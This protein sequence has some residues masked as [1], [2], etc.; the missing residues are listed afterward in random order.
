MPRAWIPPLLL[1]LLAVAAC[2]PATLTPAVTPLAPTAAPAE[3]TVAQIPPTA[4]SAPEEPIYLALIWHQHQPLYYKDPATGVYI[5]PWVRVHAAKDYLDMATTL[6]RYPQVKATFNLTPSLIRQL[7]D[8]AAGAKDLYQ[9]LAEKPAD[10]LTPEDKAFIGERFFDINPKIIARFPRYQE[11]A[12]LRPNQAAWGEAEW[13]DLQVLFNLAWT[14]PDWLAAEPLKGLVQK[15]RGFSE[16]DKE[17]LFARHLEIVRQVIPEHRK[18]QDAGQIEVTMTPYAHPI[19]PLLVS[20]RLARQSAPGLELPE[21]EFSYAQDA[22]AQLQKGVAFYEQHF[23]RPPRGMWPAE[24]AVAQ[25]IVGMVSQAGIRWM[26]SDEEVL[27]RSLGLA[28]FKRDAQETV[29]EA[30]TLYR[31]Y[32]VSS[33][34][35]PPVAII[36]RDKLISDKVGFAYAFE[37]G[38]QAARDFI[39]RIHAIRERLQAQGQAGAHLVSVILDGEN[40]WEYY[41]NDGKLFLNTLYRLLAEDPL[42]VTVTPAEF[43]AR[44]PAQPALENLWAGSWVSPDFKTWIGEEEENIAWDYLART[45]AVVSLYERGERTIAADRLAR[46]MELIYAA[47][48]SD[49]FWWYGADQNSGNDES[50]DEQF[51]AI[52]GDI[53]DT[54][55]LERPHWL[56][57]PIIASS[58]APTPVPTLGPSTPVLV[59]E[60]PAGDDTGPGTYTYPLDPVF[61]KAAYDLKTFEVLHNDTHVLFRFT[62]YGKLN[63][64]WGAPNGMGVHTVDVYIDQDGKEGSGLRKLLP[65]RNAAVSARDAWDFA[66]WAEGWYPAMYRAGPQGPEEVEGELQIISDAG[67]QQITLKVPKAVIGNDPQK[68]KYLAVVLSQEGY[69]AAG[70]WRVRDVLPQAQQWRLGGAPSDTNHTR[71]LDVALPADFTPDQAT[72]LRTYPPSQETDMDR[73]GP[74]DFAQLPMIKP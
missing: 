56:S 12:N 68:W 24:G 21:E 66:I 61:P 72:L 31:P 64:A 36:F 57:V 60:D 14:D 5:R 34:E 71:I 54:L 4:T 42:I 43:L 10:Q 33:N 18:L 17:V 30:S 23:G 7:D 13:R 59:V 67:R 9:V 19:L 46:A 69:P 51:R 28:K 73:L 63:N 62:F 6:A 50:F 49:W 27:A 37:P 11:L 70:V 44:F 29:V 20:T 74:D 3:P 16:A 26:A 41:D 35:D 48:G 8:L 22:I 25:E 40:A 2:I 1:I 55:G 39:R 52:L 32:Y 53:F 65:G 15:R 58:R 38:D 45:R 47:E